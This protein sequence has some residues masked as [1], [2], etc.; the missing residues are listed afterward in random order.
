[1]R[2][3]YMDAVVTQKERALR[4]GKPQVHYQLT[5]TQPFKGL[6]LAEVTFYPKQARPER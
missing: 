2:R 1:M 4:S 3:T 6:G 5:E